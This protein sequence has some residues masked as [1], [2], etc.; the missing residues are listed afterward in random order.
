MSFDAG[1]IIAR[2][3][4][5]DAEFDRKLRADVAKIEAFEKRSHE[6]KISAELDPSGLNRARQQFTRFDQQIT[7]DAQQRGRAH[8]SVLGALMGLFGGSRAAG[9][10]S[11]GSGRS[12]LGGLL[13]GAGP[14]PTGLPVGARGLLLGTA[15]AVGLGALPALFGG[16]LPLGVAGLGLGVA[17]IGAKALIG[18]R[19][20]A[21]RPATQG[22]LYAEAQ[23]AMKSIKSAF[24]AGIQPL[25]GPLRQAFSA[26][27]RMLRSIGPELRQLFAGAGTLIM[28]VLRA[29]TSLA[30]TVLPLLGQ[31]FRATAPLI[32]PLIGGF[33]RL[34]GG[35]LP[36]LIALLRAAS[37]A[38]HALAG[39]LGELGSGIGMMLR[40]FAP[41]VKASSVIFKA[42]GDVLAAIFPIIGK[43][44]GVFA[45]ALG[46]VFVQFARVIRSLLPFLTIM[47]RALASLAGAVLRDLV[48]LFGALAKLLLAISPAIQILARAFSQ[49]VNVLESTG[50]FAALASALEQI[51]P[52]LAR[53]VNLLIRQLAPD[54]P[55]LTQLLVVFSTTLITLVAAG[56]TTILTGLIS[57][58][59]HFPRLVPILGFVAAA[60]LAWNLVVSA[61]P[62]GLVIIAIAAL[63]GAITLLAKHW[64]RVWGDIKN[65]AMDAWNFIYHG[66]GK[67][68]LPLLG[69][70]GLIALGV[71]EL[72]QHW[73]TVWGDIK[74]VALAAWHFL[75]DNIVSP[76]VNTFTKTIPGAFRTGVRAI[77]GAWDNIKNVVR[78]P[79][80]WVV[81]HVIDGLISAFDWISGKVGGPHI[82]A[83]HPFGLATG[84][85]IPGYGGGDRHLALLEGGEAVVSKET[86]AQH[87]GTLRSWGVP[88]FQAGGRAHGNPHLPH[89][90]ADP[91]GGIGHAISGLFHDIAGGAKIIAAIASGNTTALVN[92]I[93]GMIPGGAGGAVADMAQLLL[94]IPK[95]LI[96]NA[97]HFLIGQ[98]SAPTGGALGK[99]GLG[100][101]S[102]RQIEDYWMGAGGPGGLI[103]HI[104][105]AITGPES[106]FNPRAV[107][108]GQPYATTGWGLWQITPGNSEPQFGIDQALLNPRNNAGAAVA[109]YRG[110]GSSFLPWTT[111][112]SGA[113]RAF[114]DQGGVLQPGWNT[115]LNGTGQP[116]VVLSPRESEA[117]V[118][119]ARA[120]SLL[121]RS[122]GGSTLERQMER[123]IRAVERNAGQTGAALSLALDRGSRGAA[124][125]GLYGGIA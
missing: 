37:P 45:R 72:A 1:S 103:A 86:T 117:H 33:T 10:G 56:L 78:A 42:L 124:Y 15:G 28:P 101:Q 63:V 90:M 97:V 38:V 116:E 74:G 47:G 89:G 113:Y 25:I 21:G 107:Q 88:G 48:V 76:L 39:I 46:P 35:L 50:V 2:M 125:A 29:L 96:R 11:G 84:G 41:A 67:F 22:P 23:A 73:R 115:V 112:V 24:D 123:L 31:A 40:D 104:A 83:V 120:A 30:R 18:S 70:A 95:T 98:F 93:T 53:F 58:L 61:N 122:G 62:I 110:A 65:W 60:W 59:R 52:V 4:L 13:G 32:R 12:L 102:L 17:G 94:A 111:F 3:D 121:A 57:L 9:G 85:L 6:A 68:L 49:V 100:R 81:D 92:A 36:G 82:P 7:Q 77:G 109:K 34:L 27:P 69:P 105:A 87:A 26:I 44:A 75:H 119:L 80:A 19:N 55:V 14:V 8:G 106:G 114:M 108:Q 79:V 91:G 43:L 71:I 51:A 66:F 16:A 64:S 54:L 20:V 99:G 5:D 118:M